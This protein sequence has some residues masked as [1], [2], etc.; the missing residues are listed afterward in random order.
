M[1]DTVHLSLWLR[2]FTQH[3]MLSMFERALRRFPYS[4]I[5]PSG[6]IIVYPLSYSEPALAEREIPDASSYQ[7]VLSAARE[8]AN[9]DCSYQLD[10][11]W[12][13]WQYTGDWQ[14]RPSAVSISLYAPLFES[15]WGEQIQFDLGLADLYL[16]SPFAPLNERVYRSNIKSVLHLAEDME[17][18]LP[19]E[20]RSLWSDT[21]ENL[22]DRLQD[23][24]GGGF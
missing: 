6:L 17:R 21:G 12:D 23:A 15:P 7:D 11:F 5:E 1:A 8:H 9:A 24:F 20:K 2:G 22:A 13:L 18:I 4:R 16:P 3:N 19:V 14:L 10:C